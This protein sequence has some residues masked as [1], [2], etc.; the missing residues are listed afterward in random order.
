VVTDSERDALS[1]ALLA[2]FDAAGTA[3]G[4]AEYVNRPANMHAREAAGVAAYGSSY[5]Q[6]L[7]IGRADADARRAVDRVNYTFFGA[8]HHLIVHA[9]SNAVAGIFLDV[10]IFIGSLLTHLQTAGIGAVPQYSI[11]KFPDVVRKHTAIG[12][13]SKGPYVRGR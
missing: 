9:P 7:G 3:G 13:C 11:A 10:G 12:M 6:A 5:Y 1:S 2:A 8:P 4:K